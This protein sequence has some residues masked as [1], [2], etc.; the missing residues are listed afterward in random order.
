[1]C[2]TYNVAF[3]WL[4]DPQGK[5]VPR[6]PSW[7]KP[8]LNIV[9]LI[10]SRHALLYHQRYWSLIVSRRARFENCSVINFIEP[11]AVRAVTWPLE[12]LLTIHRVLHVNLFVWP[13]L[14]SAHLEHGWWFWQVVLLR[15]PEFLLNGTKIINFNIYFLNILCWKYNVKFKI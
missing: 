7:W 14:F 1:M 9:P 5:G 6:D 4:H 11:S 15:V 2:S 3:T 12:I 10:V 13:V 8:L